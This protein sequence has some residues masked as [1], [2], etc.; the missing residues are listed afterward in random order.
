MFDSTPHGP[1][2]LDKVHCTGDEEMLMDC[3][4][5]SIGNHFCSQ[6]LQDES[7]NVAI[8]CGGIRGWRESGQ[9]TIVKLFIFT[10]TSWRVV[11]SSDK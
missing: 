7:S 6:F 2:L 5:A 3:S 8:Q 9:L 11:I 4:H 1:V 10:P